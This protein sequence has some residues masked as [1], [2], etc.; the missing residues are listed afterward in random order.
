VCIFSYRKNYVADTVDGDTDKRLADEEQEGMAVVEENRSEAA[1]VPNMTDGGSAESDTGYA[2]MGD[3][4]AS[5]NQATLT[6]TRSAGS[7][8]EN[9]FFC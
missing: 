1:I 9:S 8:G 3:T 2:S 4:A 6:R 7:W 5:E